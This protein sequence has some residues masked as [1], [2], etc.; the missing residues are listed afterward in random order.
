MD[1]NQKPEVL[2]STGA[3]IFKLAGWEMEEKLNT[4]K[5]KYAEY[6]LVTKDTNASLYMN[7]AR[8]RR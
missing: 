3:R 5:G 4:R 7:I 1:Q 8:S 6:R 2:V